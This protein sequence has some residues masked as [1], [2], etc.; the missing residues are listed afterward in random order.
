[1]LWE[2]LVMACS[3]VVVAKSRV[4][5]LEIELLENEMSLKRSAETLGIE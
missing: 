1:M 5:E 4:R 3:N 2:K